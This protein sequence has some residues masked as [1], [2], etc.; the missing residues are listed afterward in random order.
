MRWV[1]AVILAI[2]NTRSIYLVWN[3]R[4]RKG[5]Y[6]HPILDKTGKMRDS[7]ET[8][9]TRWQHGAIWHI[10]SITGPLYG[11]IHQYS[12]VR[13]KIGGSIQKVIRKY[14]VFQVAEIE[15]M[16]QVFRDAFLRK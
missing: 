8:S 11:A 12:G 7:A 5:N 15:A 1:W 10:D 6:S 4:A 16:K 2:I 3:W 13:T 14:I 9:S